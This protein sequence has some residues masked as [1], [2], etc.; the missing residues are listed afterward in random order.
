MDQAAREMRR[1]EPWELWP[2][3][4]SGIRQTSFLILALTTGH[5]H[6]PLSGPTETS[7]K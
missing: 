1:L 7:R 4:A 3:V 6:N 5:Y 2:V